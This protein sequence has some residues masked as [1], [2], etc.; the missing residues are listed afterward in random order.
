MKLRSFYY[1]LA[2][3]VLV[4]LLMS[5]GGFYWLISQ[6]PLK[7]LDGGTMATPAAAAFVPKQAPVTVSLLANP[8]RLEALGQFEVPLA[9]RRRSLAYLNEIKSSLL[10]NTGLD[11]QRDIEPWLGDEVTFAVTSWDID[12]DIENGS[13]PGYLL[14]AATKDARSSRE[15][16]EL[17]WQ[18]KAIAGTDLVFESYDGVELI[19]NR[20]LNS[21]ATAVVGSRFA[22]FSN[23]PKV[24][25]DAI[26]NVQAPDVNL[27]SS[28]QYR[29]ALTDIKNARIGLVF[30][31]LPQL[32]ALIDKESTSD[33]P[34]NSLGDRLYERAAIFLELNPKGVLVETSLLTAADRE[35]TAVNPVLSAPVNALK[36]IP[37]SSVVVAAGTNLSQLSQQLK[38]E[39]SGYNFLSE[40]V[41]NSLQDI[42]RRWGIQLGEDV[43]DKVSGNYALGLLPRRDGNE[44]DWIF[45][46]EKTAD[47]GSLSDRLDEIAKQQKY[48]IG[49]FALKGQ[50]I[51]AWTKLTK[52]SAG[53][54]ADDSRRKVLKAQVKGVRATVGNYEI[55]TTS[56]EAMDRA[57]QTPQKGSLLDRADFQDNIALL[58]TLNDGYF[59]L[60]WQSGRDILASHF[61]LLKLVETVGK[62]VFDKLRTLTISSYGSGTRER[63]A[64]IFLKLGN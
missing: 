10:D 60:D 17:F 30:L 62:P 52:I 61:P 2:T 36:Y 44:I 16:L 42:Y 55:F 51:F 33:P 1:G 21:L 40:V 25:R 53:D 18:R 19:Y 56:I 5:A 58:K 48:S 12:R 28:S 41:N 43:F 27:S 31:N 54:A 11:Y 13:Q 50:S 39:S 37:P 8:S 22:L 23:H 47:E 64:G 26:N 20:Q 29:Q 38:A 35:L 9:N 32:A 46:A 59:Y 14:I 24:L 34:E 15:L 49:P 7:L 45:I 4:L 3:I 57:I 63:Q 6:S